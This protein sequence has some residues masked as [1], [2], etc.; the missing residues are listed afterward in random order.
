MRNAAER[1]WVNAELNEVLCFEVEAA[2]LMNGFL[3]LIIRSI[4]DYFDS[5]KIKK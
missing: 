1:D 5:H 4:C 2:G 3:C